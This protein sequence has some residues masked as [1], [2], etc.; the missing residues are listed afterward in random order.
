MADSG[1]GWTSAA[2]SADTGLLRGLL[3]GVSG[4]KGGPG[5]DAPSFRGA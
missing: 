2:E 4:P 3:P 1:T 5:A